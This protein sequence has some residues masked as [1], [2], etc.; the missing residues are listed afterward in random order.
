MVW[1]GLVTTGNKA[2]VKAEMT[3]IFG[4]EYLAP[5]FNSMDFSLSLKPEILANDIPGIHQIVKNPKTGEPTPLMECII[6]LNDSHGWTREQIADWLDTLDNQ[7]KFG[8]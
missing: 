2:A 3:N 4:G 5:I 7:P 8:A 1:H 6:S